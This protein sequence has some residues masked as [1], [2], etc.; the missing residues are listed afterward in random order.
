MKAKIKT[1]QG[2]GQFVVFLENGETFSCYFDGSGESPLDLDGEE[3]SNFLR[4]LL[5]G[6][7]KVSAKMHQPYSRAPHWAGDAR[8]VWETELSEEQ[9]DTLRKVVAS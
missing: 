7:E 5:E 3:K 2:G 1:S 8:A 9:V 6:A 4:T